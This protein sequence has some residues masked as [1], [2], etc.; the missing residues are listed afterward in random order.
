MAI[1]AMVSACSPAVNGIITGGN[2]VSIQRSHEKTEKAI[3]EYVATITKLKDAGDPRGKF[4]WAQAN[5]FNWIKGSTHDP[6]ILIPIYQDA[7]S[8]GSIDARI[9][10]AIREIR[11]TSYKLKSEAQ[12]REVLVSRI[13]NGL[14][15]LEKNTEGRCWYQKPSIV[16][17][18]GGICLGGVSAA[19]WVWPALR[20]SADFPGKNEIVEYWRM[21]DV[22]CQK[23]ESFR[24]VNARC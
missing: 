6:G 21:K 7:A 4:L 8:G 9:L 16:P 13:K 3:E 12:D 5:D 10:L 11:L 17:G 20:D 18:Y 22:S 15:D 14:D 19:G 1:I 2:S 24:S 23:S